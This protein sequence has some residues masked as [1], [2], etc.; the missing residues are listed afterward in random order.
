MSIFISVEQVPFAVITLNLQFE[1]KH[2][3][4]YFLRHLNPEYVW[5]YQTGK[6]LLQANSVHDTVVTTLLEG[7]KLNSDQL[8]FW[9]DCPYPL[10]L[11]T[12]SAIKRENMA[13]QVNIIYSDDQIYLIASDVTNEVRSTKEYELAATR[14]LHESQHCPLT[15]IYNRRFVT[16]QL[17]RNYSLS[18]REGQAQ[19][20]ALLL[21]D[22]DHFKSINDKYGHNVGDDVLV[23][24]AKVLTSV[25]RDTDIASR[26]GGEEFL[27]Y[28]PRVWE[29]VDVIRVME[30]L[31]ETANNTPFRLSTGDEMQITFSSG[32]Y[33]MLTND[34][35]ENSI[36]K[37]DQ[38]MYLAKKSGRD[39]GYFQIRDRSNPIPYIPDYHGDQ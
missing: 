5:E 16:E 10:P 21:L 18:V 23:W 11:L 12:A 31:Y 35:V 7:S 27:V 26:Y 13:C 39:R 15:G 8:I 2:V 36:H 32:C 3:N 34:D 24:F 4:E 28:L 30:R 38:L 9:K 22:I 20:C 33:C 1:I 25:F 29:R 19:T 6:N 37:A 14:L 17:K